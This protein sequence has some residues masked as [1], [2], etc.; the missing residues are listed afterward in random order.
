MGFWSKLFG[1]KKKDAKPTTEEWI[2]DDPVV[3]EAPV[4]ETVTDV[5]KEPAAA[6]VTKTEPGKVAAKPAAKKASTAKKPAAKKPAKKAAAKPAAKKAD[7]KLQPQCA[8][9]TAAGDQ[10]KRSSRDGSKYCGS[11]KGYQ[12]KTAAK[13]AGAKDTEPRHKGA[14]DTKPATRKPSKAAAKAN[15]QCAAVTAAGTQC[16]SASR[17]N[18]KYCGR[19]KGYRAPA[20]AAAK[21][22]AKKAPAKKASKAQVSEGDYKLFQNGNRFYF[23]KQTQAEAK[24]K[25]GVPVYEIPAGRT[26]VK[27][28]NGLP[29]L[30]KA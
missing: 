13:I 11:H 1:T 30:K 6:P 28:A 7:K 24:A 10:C 18:S 15:E 16:K 19:H 25:G 26:V 12:P 23:S 27:T 3:A 29:V 5:A 9:V 21:P 14:E 17:D 8:A 4:A 2:D 22:A 20:K